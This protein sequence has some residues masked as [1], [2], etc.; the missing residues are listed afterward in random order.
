MREAL[1]VGGGPAGAALAIRL[2]KAGTDVLLAEK[3]AEAHHKVCGEFLSQG[4]VL[5]LHRLGVLPEALCAHPI[6]RVRLV[7]GERMVEARL[8]FRALS[9]SR[10][11]LDEAL[12]ERAEFAGVGV[13]RG[14]R[15]TR[16]ERE[17]EAWVNTVSLGG[18]GRSK[19]VFLA[20]G[21]HDIRDRHR[22]PGGHDDLLGFKQHWRLS[23]DATE[24]LRGAVE[25]H[26]FDGGYAGLERVED[27]IANLC[28]VV[29]KSAFSAWPELLDRLKRTPLGQ[30]LEGGEPCWPRPLAVSAIPYGHVQTTSDG[31]WRLGD[32][33]AVIPSFLGEGMAMALMSAEEAAD[34]YLDGKP[35]G[36]FQARFAKAVGPRVK[37]ATLLSRRLVEPMG[38]R[39]AMAA[40]AFLVSAVAGAARV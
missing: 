27:G 8:P 4:A 38:Q 30:R 3:E 7:R 32:Q 26:L 35:A 2:A 24:A 16:L 37:A 5:R 36:D 11:R 9:L 31:L 21:K 25:L 1:V 22:P 10:K 14:L 28:L 6:D 39:L 23:P 18:D 12:L 29:R 33:A 13:M 17:G 15:V 20:S 19:S 40:P 34:A